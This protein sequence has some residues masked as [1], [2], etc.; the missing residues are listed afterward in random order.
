MSPLR[1]VELLHGSGSVSV[2]EARYFWVLFRTSVNGLS[3]CLGQ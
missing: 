1:S 3:V 2:V